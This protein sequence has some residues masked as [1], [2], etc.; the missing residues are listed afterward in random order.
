MPAPSEGTAPIDRA[1]LIIDAGCAAILVP[2]T[3][4][5]YERHEPPRRT[6]G[7]SGRRIALLSAVSTVGGVAPK[8]G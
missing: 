8:T 5:S 1:L 6:P 2:S 7:F 3:I 4:A